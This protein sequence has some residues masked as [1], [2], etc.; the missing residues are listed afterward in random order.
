VGT[1]DTV[2]GERS[3]VITDTDAKVVMWNGS[4]AESKAAL[5]LGDAQKAGTK[6][7]TLTVTGAIDTAKTNVSL[8]S[9]VD[10]PS[11]W[12]RLTHPLD[13]FGLND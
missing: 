10:A 11:A 12:W 8:K 3:D 2:W 4:K 5:K 1:I 13:L 9:S 7:G 6:V